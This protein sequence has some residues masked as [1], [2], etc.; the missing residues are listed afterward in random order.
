MAKAWIAVLA[1]KEI[2]LWSLRSKLL[3]N[4][5]KAKLH[6]THVDSVACNTAFKALIALMRGMKNRYFFMPPSPRRITPPWA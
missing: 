6:R 3:S 4:L 5:A 2:K 1:E